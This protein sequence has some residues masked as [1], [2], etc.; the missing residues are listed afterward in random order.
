MDETGIVRNRMAILLLRGSVQVG[1]LR[2]ARRAAGFSAAGR[3]GIARMQPE[4]DSQK[5]CEEQPG[6]N[7]GHL[8]S[9]SQ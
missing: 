4:G 3:H 5:A 2:G 8:G 6:K 9:Y 1:V 7:F